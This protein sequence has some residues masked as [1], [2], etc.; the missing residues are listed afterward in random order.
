MNYSCWNLSPG[1]KPISRDAFLDP[2]DYAME[3]CGNQ[4]VYGICA[5]LH[6]GV[7]EAG[8]HDSPALTLPATKI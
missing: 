5:L 2:S 6:A 4:D 3:T 1:G 7:R 8:R